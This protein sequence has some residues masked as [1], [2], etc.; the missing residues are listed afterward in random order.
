MNH[1]EKIVAMECSGIEY[2]QYDN[3]AD[4]EQR[5]NALSA[6]FTVMVE[7]NALLRKRLT[8]ILHVGHND[9]CIFCAAKD[10]KAMELKDG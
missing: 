8:D 1:K 9:N 4:L 10:M 7:E 3:Y 6:K 5:F 2:V